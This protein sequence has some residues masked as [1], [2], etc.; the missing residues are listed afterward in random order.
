MPAETANIPQPALLFVPDISGFTQF[1]Q[2]TDV[3][4]SQH[5][6]EE[7][8]EKLIEAN[9]IGLQVSEVEGDAI[10]FYRFGNPPTSEEF[11]QQVR[12]MFIAFH[13]HLKLYETQRIC[14]CGACTS[15]N[16]I[17]LKIVAH[18]G[19]ITQSY[20]KEHVKLFGQDVITV[21]RLLKNNISHHEYALFTQPLL[22]E[23]GQLIIPELAKQQEGFQ[24]YDVGRISY[25]Y[26]PL[27]PLLQLIP[28]PRV[29]EFSIPGATVQVFSFEQEINAPL[30]FVFEVLIDLPA[31]LKWMEGAQKVDLYNHNLNRLGTK[32]RCI[33][34]KTSPVMVTSKNSRS[35]DTI[36]FTETDI[37]KTMCSV[38]TLR[39]E[40]GV[41][42]HVRIDGFLKDAFILRMLFTLLLK[43]KI[44]NLFKAS[45]KN[46]KQYCEELYNT[47]RKLNAD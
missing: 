16:N 26:V 41:Q 21:H 45:G 4:H 39:Q 34:D 23:W 46:L 19:Q 5:I 31:R 12:K 47:H 37:K 29:E 25:R 15:A 38:Y 2:A 22:N 8:L 27:E 1:V 11:F 43:K 33:V 10:L 17:T 9:E 6:I 7:L 20:I 36:T 40:R 24:E 44:N 30:N 3:I 32:H 42:T 18:Y 14:Q 13:S 35:A 28:E